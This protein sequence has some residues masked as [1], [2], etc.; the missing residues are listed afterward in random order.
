[1]QADLKTRCRVEDLLPGRFLQEDYIFPMPRWRWSENQGENLSSPPRLNDETELGV[2]SRSER[3][4]AFAIQPDGL[5]WMGSRRIPLPKTQD[6]MRNQVHNQGAITLWMRRGARIVTIILR[7]GNKFHETR[8]T[9]KFYTCVPRGFKQ[10]AIGDSAH[11]KLIIN[12]S[13]TFIS[14][15]FS[16]RCSSSPNFVVP[17]RKMTFN[18]YL[19]RQKTSILNLC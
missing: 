9:I 10:R 7:F 12:T 11:H 8:P 13:E 3:A 2:I 4:L 16:S 15:I 14:R 6:I 5:S 19:M 1:M 18:D 17:I